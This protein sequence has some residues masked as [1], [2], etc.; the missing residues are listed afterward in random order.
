[1][2]GGRGGGDGLGGNA[3]DGEQWGAADEA[4]SFTAH[5]LL[6]GPVPN[7]PWTGTG[8]QPRSWGPLT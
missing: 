6:C 5:L 7:R 3:S 2:G 4:S 8:P 1:M